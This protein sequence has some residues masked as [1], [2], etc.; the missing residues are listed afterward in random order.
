MRQTEKAG[1]IGTSSAATDFL[2]PVGPADF[3]A[4]KCTVGLTA[5]LNFRS[6]IEFR[7]AKW[8]ALSLA[9]LGMAFMRSTTA[10]DFDEALAPIALRR[11]SCRAVG[12]C[13]GDG[14]SGPSS[15]AAHSREVRSRW[16]F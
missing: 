9:G 16:N 5:Q 6:L 11:I 7:D 3:C 15:S 8:P 14:A 2:G 10:L 4:R 1:F 13:R 12:Q